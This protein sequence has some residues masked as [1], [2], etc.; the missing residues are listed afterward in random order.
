MLGKLES[1]VSFENFPINPEILELSSWIGK[2]ACSFKFRSGRAM[3]YNPEQL[4][5]KFSFMKLELF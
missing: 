1:T 4:I 2:N 3:N 5:L